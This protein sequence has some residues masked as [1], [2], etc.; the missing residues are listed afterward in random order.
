MD[1]FPFGRL[2]SLRL[3]QLLLSHW[4]PRAPLKIV[5]KIVMKV[6][7]Y[8]TA[9]LIPIMLFIWLGSNGHITILGI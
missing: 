6:F 7:I 9:I 3:F 1:G 5:Y 2:F 4:L 8:Y